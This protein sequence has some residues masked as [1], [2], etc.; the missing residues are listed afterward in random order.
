MITI[1]LQEVKDHL[2]IDHDIFDADLSLKMVAAQAR[3][4]SHCQGTDFSK[5]SPEEETLVKAAI[6]NLIGYMDRV[7][8]GEESFDRNYLPPFVHQLLMPLRSP[9][10]A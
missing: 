2:R 4:V 10:I 6:L 7:R 9:G 8:N 3:I 1:D 5:L